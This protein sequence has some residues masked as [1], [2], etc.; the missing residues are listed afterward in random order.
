[1]KKIL[2]TKNQFALIDD[3]D[4]EKINKIKWYAHFERSKIYVIGNIKN[5][6]P[7]KLHRLIMD[8]P[9]NMQVDHIDGNGLNNLRNNLR[10][11]T[12]QQN[13]WNRKKRKHFIE[14]EVKIRMCQQRI[15]EIR[16][17]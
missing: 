4:F 14:N 1:M 10:I 7:I 2:L 15:N 5:D 8:C 11:C 13:A 9:K 17:K 12:N 6:K 3:E 16:E